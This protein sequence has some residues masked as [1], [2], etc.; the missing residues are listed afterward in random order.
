MAA[1]NPN[2]ADQPA[3][4]GDQANHSMERAPPRKLSVERPLSHALTDLELPPL[5][6]NWAWRCCANAIT[7]IAPLLAKTY[8]QPIPLFLKRLILFIKFG[9][10]ATAR[11][12]DLVTPFYYLDQLVLFTF[13]STAFVD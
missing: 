11:Q 1:I 10:L 13:E 2:A 4:G 12:N 7:G 8:T 3:H 5:L 6:R 9:T